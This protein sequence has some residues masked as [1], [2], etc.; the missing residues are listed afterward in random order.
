[1]YAFDGSTGQQLWTFATGD[2]VDFLAVGANG[3]LIVSS[4]DDCVYSVQTVA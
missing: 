3:A 4:E 1:V 2:S